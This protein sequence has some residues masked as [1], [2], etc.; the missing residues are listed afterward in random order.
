MGS[1]RGVYIYDV[2]LLKKIFIKDHI[3]FQDRWVSLI[4]P[5]NHVMILFLWSKAIS[6]LVNRVCIN[7]W[8]LSSTLQLIQ[9][10]QLSVTGE[11]KGHN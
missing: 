3:L 4:L 7:T 6:M 11:R 8:F 10:G 9:E 5:H 2:D 1:L